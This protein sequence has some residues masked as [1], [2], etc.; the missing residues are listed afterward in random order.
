[1][2]NEEKSIGTGNSVWAKG[3]YNDLMWNGK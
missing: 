3:I 1:M 2:W